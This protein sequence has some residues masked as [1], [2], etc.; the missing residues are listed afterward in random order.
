LFFLHA[1]IFNRNLEE[2]MSVSDAQRRAS[3][4]YL[5]EKV[6]DIRFRVPKGNKDIIR[7]HAEK[8]G[9]SVNAFI[10]RAVAETMVSDNKVEQ[11]AD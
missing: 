10:N 6:E 3:N 5:K 2:N 4:K 11:R 7:A 8:M 9:E 1:A